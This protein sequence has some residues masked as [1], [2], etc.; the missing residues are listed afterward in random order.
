[1]THCFWMSG[2]NDERVL[3]CQIGFQNGDSL[4][5]TFNYSSREKCWQCL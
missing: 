4:I 1:M 2:S 3:I 5:V